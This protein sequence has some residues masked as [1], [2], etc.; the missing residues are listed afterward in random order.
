VHDIAD[1]QRALLHL[2]DGNDLREGVRQLLVRLHRVT[3]R[4]TGGVY[5]VP[6]AA[7]GAEPLLKALRAYIKG[8]LPW[9]TGQLEPSCN[10]VRLNGDD[11]TELRDDILASAITE[12]KA[13]LSDL[14]EKVEPVLQHRVKGKVSDGIAQ[15]ATEELLNI[16]AAMAAYQTSLHDDLAAV[17]DMLTLAQDAVL[18]AMGLTD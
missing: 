7:V 15:A 13:R 16:K 5:F 3:L 1:R 2:A 14:A 6:Q 11:A 8:L 9:K 10:V 12:F 18:Q 17:A 4:G